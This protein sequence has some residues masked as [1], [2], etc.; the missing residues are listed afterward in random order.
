MGHILIGTTGKICL[1]GI[2][3]M[4]K[5]NATI[6]FRCPVCKE[7]FEFDNVEE[8]ELVCCPLCGIDF[9]TVRKGQ[10]VLLESFEVT[11]KI[12][13]ESSIMVELV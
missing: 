11:P 12:Q 9:M 2:K 6:T 10:T 3:E 13:S 8:Y 7:V 5:N 4:N 1:D